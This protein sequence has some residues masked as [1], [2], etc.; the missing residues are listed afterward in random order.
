MQKDKAIQF[1]LKWIPFFQITFEKKRENF[2]KKE[3][4]IALHLLLTLSAT[5]FRVLEQ[6]QIFSFWRTVTK[7]A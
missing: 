7:L 1:R 6:S 3:K 4:Q 5:M 2:D